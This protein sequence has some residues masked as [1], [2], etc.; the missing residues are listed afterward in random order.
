[1]NPLV[2][3]PIHNL[4]D[5]SINFLRP[6]ETVSK[7]RLSEAASYSIEFRNVAVLQTPPNSPIAYD[8]TDGAYTFSGRQ[9]SHI[10][11]STSVESKSFKGN[12]FIY[13]LQR[14][15]FLHF[16]IQDLKN[17]Q[18]MTLKYTIKRVNTQKQRHRLI[19]LIPQTWLSSS[20]QIVVGGLTCFLLDQLEY[21]CSSITTKLY[22][23]A[24]NCLLVWSEL[25]FQLIRPILEKNQR[26]SEII[27][28]VQVLI[29]WTT[30]SE[31]YQPI[32]TNF[33]KKRGVY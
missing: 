32:R 13:C 11:L 4:P 8:I 24:M 7:R 29:W 18:K 17:L 6:N 19:L 33:T 5:K 21:L 15:L 20:I 2:S 26:T 22:H 1:M 23:R 9:Q 25:P 30:A 14:C 31:W 27:G 12:I 10:Q 28:P 16:Q 3:L